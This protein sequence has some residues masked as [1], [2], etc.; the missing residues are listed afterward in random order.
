MFLELNSVSEVYFCK[1]IKRNQGWVPPFRQNYKK[2][3]QT[4]YIC[5]WDRVVGVRGYII[6]ILFFALGIYSA[7][8]FWMAVFR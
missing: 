8:V 6:I 4:Y 3:Y 1:I 5:E 2:C 7:Y